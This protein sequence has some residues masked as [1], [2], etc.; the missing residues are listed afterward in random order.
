MKSCFQGF[1]IRTRLKITG[2]ERKRLD[3]VSLAFKQGRIVRMLDLAN[4]AYMRDGM[5]IIP[6]PPVAL[7]GVARTSPVHAFQNLNQPKKE[8]ADDPAV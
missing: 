5:K 4:A 3:P 6:L 8:A 2:V 7:R 1:I